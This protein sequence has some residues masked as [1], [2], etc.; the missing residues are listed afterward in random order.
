MQ[1]QIDGL[2][3][4]TLNYGKAEKRHVYHICDAV[5]AVRISSQFTSPLPKK[6]K[7]IYGERK[8]PLIEMIPCIALITNPFILWSA[9][10]HS[11]HP[12]VSHKIFSLKKKTCIYKVHLSIPKGQAIKSPKWKMELNTL[13]INQWSFNWQLQIVTILKDN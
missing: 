10:I 2:K 8:R 5:V 1:Q 13:S 3:Y 12:K 7:N 11:Q 4:R 9:I 6:E